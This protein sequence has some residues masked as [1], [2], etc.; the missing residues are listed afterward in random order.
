MC[1]EGRTLARKLGSVFLETSAKLRINVDESFV[2]LVRE[3]K[4]FNKVAAKV[5]IS[6]L[7]PLTSSLIFFISPHHQPPSDHHYKPQ[8]R[9]AEPPKS[10]DWIATRICL[11]AR[12]AVLA[13]SRN[14]KKK[15]MESG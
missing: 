15:G 6:P 7:S 12:A 4:S 5:T 11:M 3:I 9:S 13:S 8:G 2:G 1:T 14:T 10:K